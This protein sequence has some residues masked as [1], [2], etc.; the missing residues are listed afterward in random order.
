LLSRHA[1]GHARTPTE[2]DARPLRQASRAVRLPPRRSEPLPEMPFGEP[3]WMRGNAV[4][5]TVTDLFAGGG[6]SSE[7]L[8]QAG[9]DIRISTN[10]WPVS[11]ATHQLNHPETEHRTADLSNTAF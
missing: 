11:V 4:A 7:G 2:D 8:R 10:H 6:G 9:Y 3:V 5:L 1:L